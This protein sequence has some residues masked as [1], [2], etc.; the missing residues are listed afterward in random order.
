MSAA[1]I[2]RGARELHTLSFFEENSE[3]FPKL[4]PNSERARH[5][6]CFLSFFLFLLLLL[7]L[8]CQDLSLLEPG[9]SW[10]NAFVFLVLSLLGVSSCFHMHCWAATHTHDYVAP[11][12]RRRPSSLSSV[13]GRF[14]FALFVNG[15]LVYSF[16]GIPNV[17]QRP[18]WRLTNQRPNRLLC[19]HSAVC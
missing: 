4:F 15:W 2:L 14:G 11:K 18:R 9:T 12:K 3:C 8:A 17:S 5:K 6:A 16:W 13:S 7:F 10:S 1:G 19:F